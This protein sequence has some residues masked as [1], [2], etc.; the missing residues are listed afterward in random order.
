[1][2]PPPDIEL[3]L[4]AAALF[5]QATRALEATKIV[6][7]SDIQSPVHRRVWQAVRDSLETNAGTI[8]FARVVDDVRGDLNGTAPPL[9]WYADLERAVPSTADPVLC[10]RIIVRAACD[11]EEREAASGTAGDPAAVSRAAE[12]IALIR[13]RRTEVDTEPT[14][15]AED[16]AF[17]LQE[18][19]EAKPENLVEGL[20]TRPGIVILFGASGSG[21]SYAAMALGLDLVGGGG[22]FCGADGL[23]IVSRSD[24]LGEPDRVLW[25]YGTEDPRRRIKERAR[26]LWATGPHGHKP[27]APTRF[28]MASPGARC[29]GTA[30]G[31][32]WLRREVES[33][34]ATVVFLDTIQS[35]TQATLD[36]SNGQDVARWLSALHRLRDDFGCVIIPVCHTSK[37]PTDSRTMRGKADSLLG[38]QAWRALSD[39]V[40]MLDCPDGD[41]SLGTLRM[42]KGKDVD[43][44][45]RPM[46]VSMDPDTKRFYPADEDEEGNVIPASERRDARGGRKADYG[47]RDVLALRAEHPAGIEWEKVGKLLGMSRSNWSRRRQVLQDDLLRAG[48][49]V[50]GG[51]LRWPKDDEAGPGDVPEPAEDV[52]DVPEDF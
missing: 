12:I 41:A 26:E 51:H 11:R 8:D 4:I 9:S 2:T 34:K 49:V 28:K 36:P 46:R 37:T 39:G 45:P 44:P 5:G 23:Q 1:M 48:C 33:S 52:G 3:E 21:K 14:P 31:L 38:S 40:V 20:I 29:L 32:A 13:A 18:E 16:L 24:R 35:L 50:V 47:A 6:R 10:A 22:C 43:D 27:L 25:V 42:I 15:D 19:P 30:E 7:D 17:V